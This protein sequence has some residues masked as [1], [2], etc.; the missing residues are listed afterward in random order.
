MLVWNKILKLTNKKS[1][2]TSLKLNFWAKNR[3]NSPMKC[4]LWT[5]NTRASSRNYNVTIRRCL[6]NLI[7]V[8]TLIAFL[9]WFLEQKELK[10]YKAKA[11]SLLE[12]KNVIP[13]PTIN[14][15]S[16]LNF[17]TLWISCWQWDYISL[18]NY[19]SIKLE[20]EKL[21]TTQQAALTS[22]EKYKLELIVC[23]LLSMFP[24]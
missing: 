1:T 15:G 8:C 12:A 13:A 14:E 5:E 19:Y 9:I 6:S 4:R 10:Q 16:T 2:T 24:Y 17:S 23:F 3:G 18:Q 7:M 20:N 22:A 11:N 21:K